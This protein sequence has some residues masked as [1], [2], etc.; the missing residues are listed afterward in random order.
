MQ[1]Y[2]MVVGP[3]Y[4]RLGSSHY[5]DWDTSTPVFEVM[6]VPTAY[7]GRLYGR[8]E[9]VATADVELRLRRHGS[10]HEPDELR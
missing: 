8:S 10:S 3:S 1:N 7:A 9:Q 4:V 5:F 6:A 2:V